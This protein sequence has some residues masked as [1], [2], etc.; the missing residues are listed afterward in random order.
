[1]INSSNNLLQSACVQ[2]K[3]MEGHVW[4]HYLSKLG[5][6]PFHVLLKF[7]IHRVLIWEV[8]DQSN[9]R[10]HSFQPFSRR[11]EK[12][13]SERNNLTVVCWQKAVFVMHYKNIPSFN[14]TTVLKEI[15]PSNG[16]SIIK[17]NLRNTTTE[18]KQCIYLKHSKTGVLYIYLNSFNSLQKV[19]I[20]FKSV[21]SKTVYY[22]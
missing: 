19:N 22:L 9:Q 7:L 14:I 17:R 21:T 4:W 13:S 18:L 15:L 6:H 11:R 12:L 1:M 5:T 8:L 16:K 10:F 20:T 2:T 3:E